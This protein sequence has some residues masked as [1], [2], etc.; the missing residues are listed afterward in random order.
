M[1]FRKLIACVFAP[2]ALFAAAPSP[3]E[4][5]PGNASGD[6][7]LALAG[8]WSCRSA[9]GATARSTGVRDGNTLKIHD[10]VVDGSGKRS[11]FDDRYTFDTAQR[12]WHVESGYAGFRADAPAW[13]GGPWTLEGDDV[14]GVPWRMTVDFLPNGNFRRSFSYGD[15]QGHFAVDTIELCAPGMTPPPAD[16]CIADRY[17]ATTLEP[18]MVNGRFIPANAYPGLVQVVVSLNERSEVVKVRLQSSTNAALNGPAL[19]A[20]RA[21]KF[22]TAIV[23]CKPI[24]ADYIFSVTFDL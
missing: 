19:A 7:V 18:A 9:A 6:R 11:S 21:S 3:G 2:L 24:A 15:N 13:T 23:N 10:D 22:R 4:L 8:T 16:A 12:R 5:S 1:V 17:P 14:N 20:A